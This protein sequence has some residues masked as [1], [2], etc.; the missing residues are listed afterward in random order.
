MCLRA[1]SDSI[2][3][4][5]PPSIKLTAFGSQTLGGFNFQLTGIGIYQDHPRLQD[6]V[7]LREDLEGP[8]KAGANVARHRKGVIDL[9]Q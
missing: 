4:K 3:K 1:R 7:L 2:G 8:L 5:A 9:D 6:T